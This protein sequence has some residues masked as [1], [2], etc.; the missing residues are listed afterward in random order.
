MLRL[1]TFLLALLV[2]PQVFA[3]C[4][5]GDCEGGVGTWRASNGSEFTAKFISRKP[6]GYAIWVL[7]SYQK[8]GI[9]EG[10]VA[11]FQW[12]KNGTFRCILNDPFADLF[13]SGTEGAV[14]A[15]NGQ[16]TMSGTYNGMSLVE[17]HPVDVDKLISDLKRLRSRADR[18]ILRWM[19]ASLEFLPSNANSLRKDYS[20]EYRSGDR[21]SEPP[22]FT[23]RYCVEGD[24]HGGFGIIDRTDEKVVSRF[25][26]GRSNGHSLLIKPDGK[27]CEHFTINGKVSGVQRCILKTRTSERIG[28]IT[29]VDGEKNGPYMVTAFD[30]KIIMH[31]NLIGSDFT[32]KDIDQKA[33]WRAALKIREQSDPQVMQYM[34]EKLRDIPEPW[35]PSERPSSNQLTKTSESTGKTSPA[36]KSSCIEGDCVNGVGV[37]SASTSRL[38]S[39]FVNGKARG[40]QLFLDKNGGGC[41]GYIIRDKFVGV[42]RC[43]TETDTTEG[44]GYATYKDGERNGPYLVADYDG[45]VIMQGT[46]VGKDF[47][48]GDIDHRALWSRAL[49]NRNSADPEI[50]ARL[51]DVL[52]EIPEVWFPEGNDS[53]SSKTQSAAPRSNNA[54]EKSSEKK[55]ASVKR[56]SSNRECLEGNCENGV[57][58][59][60]AK[61]KS[62][63]FWI[64]EFT[65]GEFDGL[66][67]FYWGSGN[68]NICLSRYV[69]NKR[70]GISICSYEKDTYRYQYYE[71]GSAEGQHFIYI[72]TSGTISDV[73]RQ[74][75]GKNQVEWVDLRSFREDLKVLYSTSSAS[76]AKH[77]PDRIKNAPFP[78]TN[79]LNSALRSLQ[80]KRGINI[81]ESAVERDERGT[82]TSPVKKSLSKRTCIDGN[83]QNGFGTLR[84]GDKE[85]T[86]QFYDGEVSGYALIFEDG[87]Y[88][89]ARMAVGKNAGISHCYSV[90]LKVHVLG[91][92]I[93]D[94][95]KGGQIF[96][97][98]TGEVTAYNMYV[99]GKIQRNY[100]ATEA[101]KNSIMKKDL[102]DYLQQLGQIRGTRPEGIQDWMPSELKRI[103]K[104]DIPRFSRALSRTERLR[105]ERAAKRSQLTSSRS[106]VT[107][108]SKSLPESKSKDRSDLQKLSLIAAELNGNKRQVNPDYRLD[109]VRID[110]NDFELRYEFS[111][112]RSVNSLDKSLLEMS[113]KTAYCR[114]SKLELF[115]KQKMSARWIY[116]DNS[117][118]T[119]EFLTKPEDC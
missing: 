77:I 68:K 3:D 73:G 112:S 117:G 91:N 38:V 58:K 19:P 35:F 27:S 57:G 74:I 45:K 110:P 78:S 15:D 79:D 100:F 94:G 69:D 37:T 106:T 95:A 14:I 116:S 47:K 18:Q 26:G 56:R 76:F 53:L 41:E 81:S 7:P 23:S 104:H 22:S 17:N 75:D 107:A 82:K 65:D 86:G 111:S 63:D 85:Y 43:T 64:A 42:S 5:R 4:I 11:G 52:K 88:C 44:I 40:Y 29:N 12:R 101:D 70:E 114:A 25:I 54:K 46:L 109:R 118:G 2:T 39:K 1:K 92:I 96:I 20:A 113:G 8:G 10:Q 103:P 89:E 108:Q 50:L 13:R 62:D 31:G 51:P 66:N 80:S 90:D 105:Q 30:G 72:D 71:Q 55:S 115:R 102:R 28:Y 9:C 99:D 93:G 36:F 49:R 59:L 97:S 48:E 83:C 60:T 67:L 61:G 98:D 84:L 32:T 87:I 21:Q 16:I 34:P 119:F 24:C 6:Q 33:L